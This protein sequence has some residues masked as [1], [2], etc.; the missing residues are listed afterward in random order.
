MK[1]I[2]SRT[3][4]RR[5]IKVPGADT[6]RSYES[7][8]WSVYNFEIAD[9]HHPGLNA[10]Y[11]YR[12]R[13]WPKD[14]VFVPKDWPNSPADSDPP[15][16][17]KQYDPILCA[18]DIFHDV[19]RLDTQDHEA[20]LAF[21]NRWGLLN[22][23]WYA[24][25]AGTRAWL[26][27]T[28]KIIADLSALQQMKQPTPSDWEELAFYVNSLVSRVHFAV[29]WTSDGLRP[30]F[31]AENLADVIGLHL[32]EV[33]TS[34]QRLRQ[35]AYDRC[36]AFFVPDR[37]D[38]KFCKTGGEQKC[39]RLASLERFRAGKKNKRRHHK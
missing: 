8:P 33:A 32:F 10:I 22:Q 31:R 3:T 26:Q 6:A 25:V 11:G 27:A 36:H 9:R 2:T 14:G 39:A 5:E 23:G 7:V 12:R 19:S 17:I 18:E 37:R 29:R 20:M 15:N 30:V 38:Q 34:V 1:R 35:C 16:P 4:Q 28:K 24:E 21:M 13:P